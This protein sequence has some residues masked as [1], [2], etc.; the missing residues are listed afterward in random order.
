MCKCVLVLIGCQGLVLREL[1]RTRAGS[2]GRGSLLLLTWLKGFDAEEEN[3][4]FEEDWKGAVREREEIRRHIN[5]T[6]SQLSRSFTCVVSWGRKFGS[7]MTPVME[8]ERGFCDDELAVQDEMGSLMEDM[9]LRIKP[10]E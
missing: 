4:K 10:D 1:A 5:H 3:E 7:E 6:V 2:D 9:M 8:R